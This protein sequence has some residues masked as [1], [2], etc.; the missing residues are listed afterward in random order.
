[1]DLAPLVWFERT[2]RSTIT[3]RG[4]PGGGRIWSDIKFS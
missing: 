1:L 4:I 2:P 3:P